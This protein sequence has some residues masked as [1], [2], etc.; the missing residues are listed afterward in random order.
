MFVQVE[1][2]FPYYTK[3]ESVEWRVY[4]SIIL[5]AEKIITLSKS[6]D[7]YLIDIG[8]EDN[9]YTI[10][11]AEYA[12]LSALL[13]PAPIEPAAPMSPLL[14]KVLVSYR[15]YKDT[16]IHTAAWNSRFAE[17]SFHL[18]E[19]EESLEGGSINHSKTPALP[20]DVMEWV[21]NLPSLESIG[22]NDTFEHLADI[23]NI[24]L[25]YMPKEAE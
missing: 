20:A 9:C 16:I 22:G 18:S 25:D 1:T 13:M 11:P 10:S 7:N 5:N 24:L 12:R 15:K 4:N 17:L 8:N 14:E 3:D 6:G 19:W 21:K 2:L 23:T